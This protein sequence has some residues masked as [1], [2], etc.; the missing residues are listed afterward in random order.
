MDLFPGKKHKWH[1]IGIAA[2][3]TQK[4]CVKANG[5]K[6]HT[7]ES[8]NHRERRSNLCDSVTLWLHICFPKGYGAGCAP[9]TSGCKELAPAS[10]FISTGGVGKLGGGGLA[11]ALC[12]AAFRAATLLSKTS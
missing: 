10:G 6:K 7:T 3:E 9:A 4:G 11:G 8:Q 5:L 2:G 1:C 12:M